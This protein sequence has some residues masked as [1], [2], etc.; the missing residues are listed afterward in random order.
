MRII[1]VLYVDYK[2]NTLN[3][4]FNFKV[5]ILNLGPIAQILILEVW[6][7]AQKPEF[8][9]SIQIIPVLLVP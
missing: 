1:C 3:L 8:L 5:R 7:G 6:D 4:P 9:I 2:T